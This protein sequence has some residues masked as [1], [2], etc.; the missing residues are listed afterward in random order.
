MKKLT[1]V[2][3]ALYVGAHPDD[4]NTALLATLSLGRLMRTGYLALNR[5]EGGQNLIGTEQGDLL[6]VIRT[7]ELLAARKVDYAEQFFTRAVDFGFSKSAEESVRLVGK[8]G[9]SGRCCLGISH[10]SS[11]CCDHALSQRKEKRTGTIS[12]ARSSRGRLLL[13]QEIQTVSLSN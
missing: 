9:C 11:G 8:R 1:V 4:E 7:Q 5:G 2:G 3:N 13:L 6:G 12:R 10:F